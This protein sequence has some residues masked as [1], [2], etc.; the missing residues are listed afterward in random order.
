MNSA[1]V[2][3]PAE[4]FAK[5]AL[6]NVFNA[7]KNKN[8]FRFEAGAGA[9]KTYSLVQTLNYLIKTQGKE[10]KRSGKRIATITY[11]NVA[12]DEIIS[13]TDGHPVVLAETIHSFC[14]LLIKDFQPILRSILPTM[15]EKW[16]ER[17]TEKG[18]IGNKTVDYNL[19]YPKITEDKVLLHH[20]DVLK[21]MVKMLEIQKFRVLLTNKYPYLFI[22]E[23]QDT[24]KE[25]ANSIKTHFIDTGIG[26]LIGLFGDHWQKIYGTSAC[27]LITSTKLICIGKEA[28]FRSDKVIVD[29]LNKFRPELIQHTKSDAK[30]GSI[31]VFNT[32]NWKGHRRTEAHWKD[33]LPASEAHEY[34]LKV[35]NNLQ[36]SGWDFDKQVTKILMLTHNLLAEEQGYRN[37]LDIFDNKDALIKKEDPL[38]SFFVDTI[39]PMCQEY[40]TGHYGAMFSILGYKVPLIK[41]HAEKAKWGS[42]L[43]KLFQTRTTGTIGDVLEQLKKTGHPRLPEKIDEINKKYLK[44][45]AIQ[46]TERAPEDADFFSRIQR[47]LGVLYTE[48][49]ALE[50][51]IKDK[52][53]F[54]TNHGVKGAEFENVL[55]VCGRGWNQ[56]NFGQFL[57]WFS[58]GIPKGKQ[59]TFERNRNLFYVACSRPKKRLAIY[60]SQ[61]LSS[62]ALSTL[63]NLFGKNSIIAL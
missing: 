46:E 25:F 28:N 16:I 8:S 7:I 56:Y 62:S 38:I 21:L 34:F 59:D 49:I 36:A 63:E 57:E 37:L 24:E 43:N 14:W 13:R 3:N 58:S 6:D 15:T 50:G 39:E 12:K 54:A 30:N 33:D 19:G 2:L 60:F 55:V 31:T 22:D 45:N 10:L 42:D 51:F 5:I 32:N 47:L 41:N 52:T 20:D 11:T 18:P 23:Y 61:E 26:P 17:F 40:I 35:K 53:P 9:G 27:G 4:Q 48:V 44:I 29:A 1:I